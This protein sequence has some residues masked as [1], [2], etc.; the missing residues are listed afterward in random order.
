MTNNIVY[1][2]TVIDLYTDKVLGFRRT[3]AIFTDVH[4]AVYVVKNNICD[5]SD[6]INYQYAV[7]EESVLNVVR[8]SLDYVKPFQ[9][10]FKYN[11]VTDE[12][13]QC[14]VP[15]QLNGQSGFGIG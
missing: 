13:E 12:F 3:P 15:H 14:N 9:L 10:W 8:P 2:V 11:S 7:I 4:Q 5:L 6:G 1:T